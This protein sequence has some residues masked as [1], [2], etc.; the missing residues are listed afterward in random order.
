MQGQGLDLACYVILLHLQLIIVGSHAEHDAASCYP[1]LILN[2]NDVSDKTITPFERIFT[3]KRV[4]NAFFS[5]TVKGG[6]I[7]GRFLNIVFYNLLTVE[8]VYIRLWDSQ[9]CRNRLWLS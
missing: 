7:F 5:N 1:N 3:K 9:V 8:D 4:R 2:S 6:V